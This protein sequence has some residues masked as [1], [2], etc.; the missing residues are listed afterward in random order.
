MHQ[1]IIIAICCIL[2]L[3]ACTAVSN[4]TPTPI[5]ELATDAVTAPSIRPSLTPTIIPSSIS[6]SS[7]NSQ[8]I[9]DLTNRPDIQNKQ[10]PTETKVIPTKTET[11][12]QVTATET[13]IRPTS[14]NTPIPTGTPTETPIAWNNGITEII[15]AE[16]LVWSPTQNAF[17]SYQGCGPEEMKVYFTDML[18][19]EKVD[20]TPSD[21]SP[22]NATLIW[23]PSGDYFLFSSES[24]EKW[25]EIVGWQVDP[26]TLTINKS[27]AADYYWGWLNDELQIT[28]RYVSSDT[29][30]I[31]IF[32]TVT[33]ESV[34]HTHFAGKVLDVSQNYVVLTETF[35]GTYGSSAAIF[36]QYEINPDT[37]LGSGDSNVKLLGRGTEFEGVHLNY[38]FFSKAIDVLPESDKILVRTWKEAYSDRFMPQDILNGKFSTN[39][40]L[41]D[42]NTDELTIL[43]NGGIDGRFSPSGNELLTI[44]A[45]PDAPQLEL[46]NRLT[47]EIIITQPAYAEAEEHRVEIAAYTSFS[48]NGRFLTY[49][50][51]EQNL[52]IYDIEFGTFLPV[53][54]AVPMTP[55]WS[56]DNSR[57]VYQD[58]E[59]GLSV[60]EVDSN[61]TYPLALSS[62][63]KL[64]ISNPQWSFDGSYLSVSVPCAGTAVL[65]LP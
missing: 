45:F 64:R 34:S 31:G 19:L 43:K 25:R 21:L 59:L 12:L 3:G 36:A 55:I 8:Q 58:P 44:S 4:L 35:A 18:Q 2:L 27:A 42:A 33:E 15:R 20:L 32:N 47:N 23:H 10:T 38:L 11:P 56:P 40:Q 24:Q 52:I 17:A 29:F 50:S 61:T 37:L 53:V 28:E 48:P 5:P 30:A 26:T 14:T 7:P 13:P 60:F 65:Q 22:C 46:I 39:L 62:C 49:Y 54:T 41:W 16:N 63:D 51:P 9:S 1:S 6:E 57:F